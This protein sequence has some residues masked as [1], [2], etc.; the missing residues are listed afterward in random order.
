MRGARYT[1]AALAAVMVLWQSIVMLTG[2]PSYILPSV[3]EVVTSFAFNGAL[4]GEHMLVTLT[5]VILG[6]IIGTFLGF[7]T[8]LHLEM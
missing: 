7:V 3:G 1:V 2:V 6:L 4:I 5:E 8:A